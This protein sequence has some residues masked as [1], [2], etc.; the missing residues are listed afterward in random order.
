MT[1]NNGAE[2]LAAGMSD[3][4]PVIA[5]REIRETATVPTRPSAVP[6]TRFEQAELRSVRTALQ[7]QPAH[8]RGEGEAAGAWLTRLS[9][10]LSDAIH[11]AE[12]A[13]VRMA[14][15]SLGGA[16]RSSRDIESDYTH[17]LQ[18]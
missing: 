12:A 3:H 1:I 15:Q 18:L 17:S 7:A 2:C 6:T 10:I 8:K 14:Q 16:G 13:R 11:S 4:L 5:H 9:A